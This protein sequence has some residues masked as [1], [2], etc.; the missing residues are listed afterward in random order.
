MLHEK[1]ICRIFRRCFPICLLYF[2]QNF[3]LCVFF[4]VFTRCVHY[5]IAVNKI[6]YKIPLFVSEISTQFPPKFPPNGRTNG[7]KFPPKFR[8]FRQNPSNL[9][10]LNPG[11]HKKTSKSLSC[12]SEGEVSLLKG[13]QACAAFTFY[14]ISADEFREIFDLENFFYF[15]N[16]CNTGLDLGLLWTEWKG[17]LKNS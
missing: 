5:V 3:Q 6:A 1:R 11:G 7:R 16:F 8:K 13:W 14:Q 12:F 15:F 4:Q 2:R 17:K 10:R 9:N